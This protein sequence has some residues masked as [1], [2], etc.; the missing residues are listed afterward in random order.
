MKVHRLML[1]TR[2]EL[3]SR[4]GRMCREERSWRNGLLC[5]EDFLCTAAF[6]RRG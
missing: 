5:S 1:C 4:Q 6:L 3:L 2:A